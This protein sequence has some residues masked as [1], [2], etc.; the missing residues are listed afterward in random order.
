M[1]YWN[2]FIHFKTAIII[3]Y[4]NLVASHLRWITLW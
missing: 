1:I 3:A 2:N 4:R